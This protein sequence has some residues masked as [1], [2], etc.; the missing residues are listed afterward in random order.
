MALAIHLQLLG[1][2]IFYSSC[3]HNVKDNN[4][5]HNE[6]PADVLRDAKIMDGGAALENGNCRL[7]TA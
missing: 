5:R 2:F 4:D 7:P 1:L 3:R 6:F